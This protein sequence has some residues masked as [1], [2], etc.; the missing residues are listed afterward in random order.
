MARAVAPR[1]AV[2]C[3]QSGVARGA[4]EAAGCS[5]GRMNPLTPN[6]ESD[7]PAG[8]TPKQR[9]AVEEP[10]RPGRAGDRL[11]RKHCADDIVLRQLLSRLDNASGQE[12]SALD[13]VKQP[14]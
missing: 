4:V 1:R 6:S 5:S 12:P 3:V 10:N 11:S 2:L 7:D 13:L 14:V 8:D 9:P